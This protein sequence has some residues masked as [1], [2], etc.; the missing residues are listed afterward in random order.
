MVIHSYDY[1]GSVCCVAVEPKTCKRM[2]GAL[3]KP[4]FDDVDVPAV[5]IKFRQVEPRFRGDY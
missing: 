3:R 1:S 4:A 2:V 5:S